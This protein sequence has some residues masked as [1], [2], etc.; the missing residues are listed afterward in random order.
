MAILATDALTRRYGELTAVNALTISVEV[1]EVFG[2]LGPNGAGKTTVI[3]MLTT[4]LPPTSGNAP[5]AGFDIAHHAAD[6]RRVIGYVP[7]LLSADGALRL[8][9]PEGF[10]QAIRRPSN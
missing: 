5:I 2:L 4:L 3:K 7:Q 6:V 9:E 8:R 10:H 1:G